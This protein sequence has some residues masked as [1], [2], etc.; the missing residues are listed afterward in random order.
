MERDHK[1]WGSAI[2]SV[3]PGEVSLAMVLAHGPHP[4][5]G[6]APS[7]PRPS[8]DSPQWVAAGMRS[9]VWRK[10]SGRI[11]FIRGCDVWGFQDVDP[12]ILRFSDLR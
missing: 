1:W 11:D 6:P 2:P 4:C 9:S 12:G 8:T 7:P 5:R 3:V 10:H